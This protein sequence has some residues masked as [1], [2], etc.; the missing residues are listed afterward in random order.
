MDIDFVAGIIVLGFFSLQGIVMIFSKG[1]IRLQKPKGGLLPWVYNIL[2]LGIILILTPIIG[3]TLIGKLSCTPGILP[4]Q[5]NNATLLFLVSITG[6]LLFVM[7]SLL[8]FWSRIVLWENFRLGGVVPRGG[9]QLVVMGPYK[10][11]RHPTYLSIILNIIGLTL[12]SLS[13]VV[14]M[15]AVL[16]VY[17]VVKLIP[18]EEAQMIGF[19]KEKYINYRKNVKKLIP[20]IY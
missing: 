20:F 18:I 9:D 4:I 10:L 3:F 11:V 8:M 16:L 15:L 17:L 14:T 1:S 7:G 5:I 13:I 19:Y 6:I 12:L 2:N